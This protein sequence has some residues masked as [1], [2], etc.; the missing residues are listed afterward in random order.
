MA[1]VVGDATPQEV[2]EVLDALSL[3]TLAE[4]NYHRSLYDAKKAE[5]AVLYSLGMNLL[6]V[7]K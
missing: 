6:E 5:A 2:A 4:T 3:L 7:Y 1:L